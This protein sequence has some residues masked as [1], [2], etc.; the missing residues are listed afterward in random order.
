M[1][2]IT[3]LGFVAGFLTTINV[4]PQVIKSWKLKKTHDISLL[5]YITLVAGVALWLVY[6][7][8]I[9]DLPLIIANAVTLI[10]CTTML[11]FKIRFG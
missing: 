6:G 11:V 3:I 4:L 5:M 10:L 1:N 9:E 8:L 2:G 7:I